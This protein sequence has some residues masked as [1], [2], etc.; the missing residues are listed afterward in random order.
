[1]REQVKRRVRRNARRAALLAVALCA[2]STAAELVVGGREN[3]TP[4]ASVN[5]SSNASTQHP[6]SHTANRSDSQPI[7]KPQSQRDSL[8][9]PPLPLLSVNPH[10][11]NT[12]PFLSASQEQSSPV[13]LTSGLA[14]FIRGAAQSLP[15]AKQHSS[16]KETKAAVGVA[17]PISQLAQRPSPEDSKAQKLDLA[18][19]PVKRLQEPALPAKEAETTSLADHIRKRIT[20]DKPVESP[21]TESLIANSASDETATA[22]SSNAPKRATGTPLQARLAASRSNSVSTPVII[23]SN[24]RIQKV[25]PLPTSVSRDDK[26]LKSEAVQFSLSDQS[27]NRLEWHKI[28]DTTHQDASQES[29]PL[30][31]LPQH[32]ST[33][34]SREAKNLPSGYSFSLSDREE[35]KPMLAVVVNP[36]AASEK[37]DDRIETSASV[38]TTDVSSRSEP[39]PNPLS[40][41]VA[42]AED[43]L[44]SDAAEITSD[45]QVELAEL[46]LTEDLAVDSIA[47]SDS[48][49]ELAETIEQTKPVAGGP[50]LQVLGPEVKGLDNP[51]VDQLGLNP[52]PG[53]REDLPSGVSSAVILRRPV[54]N[55]TQVPSPQIDDSATAALDSTVT[56]QDSSNIEKPNTEPDRPET[57]QEADESLVTVDSSLPLL[58]EP[59]QPNSIADQDNSGDAE[60][61]LPS[62]NPSLHSPLPN[63]DSLVVNTPT[64]PQEDSST[65][66][67]EGSKT[68]VVQMPATEIHV[69]ENAASGLA[70]EAKTNNNIELQS[71]N[72]QEQRLAQSELTKKSTSDLTKKP[73][74]VSID[75][76]IANNQPRHSKTRDA[77]VG[78]PQPWSLSWLLANT[79][80]PLS[81]TQVTSKDAE[82]SVNSSETQTVEQG[83][84][85]ENPIAVTNDPADVS[86]E[87]TSQSRPLVVAMIAPANPSM[88]TNSDETSNATPVSLGSENRVT[89]PKRS[90]LQEQSNE[91]AAVLGGVVEDPM[92]TPTASSSDS[93]LPQHRVAPVAISAVPPKL[94]RNGSLSLAHTAQQSLVSPAA[95]LDMTEQSMDSQALE[96]EPQRFEPFAPHVKRVPLFMKRAQ[97]RSMTVE[98][99]LRDIRIADTNV[100]QA[101]AVGPNRLKLIAAGSGVTEMV[102]WADTGDATQPVRM[103]IFKIHVENVDPSVAEG[104]R[105]TQ[106]LHEA[107]R[108]AYPNCDV[109]ISHAGADLIVSG[110][111][112]NG[113]AAE[114]IIRMVRST[115]LVTVHDRLSVD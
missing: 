66:L 84:R 35:E 59:V 56:S 95:K 80:T 1:M 98:G 5:Q 106:L 85:L 47:M 81:A 43:T 8:P 2:S 62:D 27:S 90:S 82:P 71:P 52:L 11:E 20:E 50:E 115:C 114:K 39:G 29:E 111:C 51:A 113:D 53:I 76:P 25:L 88:Q 28:G 112:V 21:Q 73:I 101:V 44:D 91:I 107:I 45:E 61:A 41:Q 104:G 18:P 7:S 22:L 4:I 48:A 60:L 65:H 94:H 9:I 10:G 55:L 19:Q 93:E 100:C 13:R 109:T 23:D 83:N 54:A 110:R 32:A 92:E 24:P 99:D 3:P 33:D 97:V 46:P 70:I 36:A 75:S 31:P 102:I 67:S 63:D 26:E 77:I 87:E 108:N 34:Q 16:L 64:K 96:F 68:S 57:H 17:A 105:T 15:S 74:A 6:A 49:S 69:P 42:G 30:N 58:S 40:Q 38:V 14:D 86:S 37:S 72:S 12:H 89:R 103:R 79:D 78:L